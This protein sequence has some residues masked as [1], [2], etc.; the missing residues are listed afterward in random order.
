MLYS[1]RLLNSLLF[2]SLAALP[3]YGQTLPSITEKTVDMDKR[4]GFFPIY[5]SATTGEIY[6]E[7]P[8]MEQEFIYVTSMPSGLGS[9]DIGLDRSQLGSTRLVRF[10]RSG[11]K[12]LLVMPN[13]RY[14]A[15]SASEA[16][17]ASVQEAFAEAILWGFTVEAQEAGSVL[18]NATDFVVRDANNVI[19][20][21]RLA[22]QGKYSM[23]E[24]RSAPIPSMLKAFPEN[25]EMEARITF[26]STDP[27][28]FVRA[29]AAD[30]Y[31]VTLSVRHSFVKLPDEG[32]T[33]R[34]FHPGSGYGFI[35]YKDYAAPLGEDMVKRFIRR[36]RLIK[37]HP[38][39]V[40]SDPVSPIVYYLDPG[41]PEPVRGALLD[42]ASWWSEAFETAGFS[43]AFRIEMLPD[44]ADPMDMRYNTIQW[45]HRS[46]R[47]WSYGASVTDP[48]TGEIIK[49]HVSLGSLRV[50]QDYLIAEGLL[51]PYHDS[52]GLDD[53]MLEMSL[54]RIRQLSAHEVG[55]TLGLSHNFASSANARAS[56]MDY[57]APY[58]VLDENG[59]IDL[60]SAYATGIGKWDKVA[61]AYGYALPLPNDREEDLLASILQ[62]AWDQGLLYITDSDA[63]P[64]GAAHPL[65]NLW[66]NG[67][68]PIH[69]LR[70]EMAVREV[71][72]ARFGERV[73]RSGR[74][75][76]TVEEALVPL[77]LRHRYQ[78][79]ATVKLLGGLTY[80][81]AMRGDRQALM[82]PIEGTIQ[83][84][85][86]QALL[87]V[88]SV[89]ALRIP[90]RVHL[91]LPPRPPGFP[92]DRELFPRHTGLT[93]DAYTPAAAVATLVFVQILNPERAARLAYQTDHDASLPDLH[94]VMEEI[95]D[96]IWGIPVAEDP[97]DAELQRVVQQVWIDEL[98]RLAN[99]QDAAPPVRALVMER[100]RE[101]VEWIPN[102]PV[103]R[104]D[105][106]TRYHR[107]MVLDEIERYLLRD[108]AAEERSARTPIPSGS[109]IGASA[110]WQMRDDFLAA[111]AMDWCSH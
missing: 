22:Q 4:N 49:G 53:P 26:T 12:I 108:Y 48:R 40:I 77:Y 69:A 13:L 65:A 7:I 74:P 73:I 96:A 46:T 104:S 11:P 52:L 103:A 5:W 51:A 84:D 90:E 37:Q 29:V 91:I 106:E 32:Y 79:E 55:H 8:A 30:P 50:R 110:R 67:D 94:S 3:V 76:A 23:D 95:S 21:L 6:L 62:Q 16:E 20:R 72:L 105:R 81:Y 24:N 47:G 111:A 85:A 36:H 2:F 9:N 1:T 31:S 56:V 19:E 34:I 109:P 102:A 33:P 98:I 80:T 97:Y 86:L 70:H 93:F 101:F 35:R 54:A 58:A 38:D 71:A 10:E 15:D 42:G 44:G 27:G 18:V 75:L 66:D 60:R 39:S 87:E 14:R 57:P 61:I 92:M 68:D 17:R 59:E 78:L 82:R 43:N 88:V 63:R 45:V 25:T 83:L 99:N 28:R 41:T 64:V 107:R 89:S 100:L